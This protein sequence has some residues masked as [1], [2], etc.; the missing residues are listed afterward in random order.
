MCASL[1][2]VCQGTLRASITYPWFEGHKWPNFAHSNLGL[3][4][5]L[6][7]P[8]MLPNNRRT[9]FSHNPELL[10]RLKPPATIGPIFLHTTNTCKLWTHEFGLIFHDCPPWLRANIHIEKLHIDDLLFIGTWY[11]IWIHNS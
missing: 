10:H 1:A 3:L 11:Q 7:L 4:L 9:N 6:T 5:T 8:W 2:A